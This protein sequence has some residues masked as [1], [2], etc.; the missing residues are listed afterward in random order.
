[1][2]TASL[3]LRDLSFTDRI[4][5]AEIERIRNYFNP[6]MKVL[7][8]GGRTGLQARILASWECVVD[9]YDIALPPSNAAPQYF[10]IKIYDGRH[11]PVPDAAYDAIYSSHMLYWE[12]H[13]PEFFAE[14]R[15]VLPPRGLAVHILPTPSWRVLTCLM[16]YPCTAL[17][18]MA[19][20][21]AS[22]RR[23]AP[24]ALGPQLSESPV[25][26]TPFSAHLNLRSKLLKGIWPGPLGPA[27][28]VWAEFCLWQRCRLMRLF[29]ERGFRIVKVVPLGIV[30]SGQKQFGP[31]LSIPKRRRLNRY[32][33]SSS[34]AFITAKHHE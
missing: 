17:L 20:M 25:L 19:G 5:C 22:L 16:H 32:W 6:G 21:L 30:Y 31:L 4:R 14:M 7:E 9:S 8:L 13:R 11:L 26:R 28:S 2:T 29:E 12:L 33:G 18:I 23:R 34:T 10:E 1:M 27:S 15:R 24:D 3:D